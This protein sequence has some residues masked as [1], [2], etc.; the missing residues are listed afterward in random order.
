MKKTTYLVVAILVM[1]LISACSPNPGSSA[2]TE[3]M[4]EFHPEEFI[5][6]GLKTYLS[7]GSST[8]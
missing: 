7:G 8:D 3:L 6:D 4:K 5:T 1:A 2:D